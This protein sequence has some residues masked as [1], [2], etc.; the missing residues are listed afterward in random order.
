MQYKNYRNSKNYFKETIKQIGYD[1]KTITES[2]E[3][4][5][6]FN[7]FYSTIGIK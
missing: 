5:N 3:L 7:D 6:Y 1:S 4:A 2:E